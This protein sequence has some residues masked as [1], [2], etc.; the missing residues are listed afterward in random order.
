LTELVI[1]VLLLAAVMLIYFLLK[2]HYIFAFRLMQKTS[3][4]ETNK[5]KIEN[6]RKYF[7]IFLKLLLFTSLIG[8]SIFCNSCIV[9][10]RSLEHL[11]IDLWSSIP[12]GFWVHMFFVLVRIAILIVLMRYVLKAIFRFLDKQEKKVIAKKR[13]NTKNVTL[14][15]LRIH[16]TIKYTFILGVIYR[17]IHFFPFLAEVSHLF[18]VALILF[19]IVALAITIKELIVM[20][21][22]RK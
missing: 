8:M 14:V 16:N 21:Q 5:I 19:L 6:I 7:F 22:T 9:E 3:M 11:V 18:L 13:Y 20:I 1:S 2:W 15:Y 17:I 10:H 4:Y 12:E